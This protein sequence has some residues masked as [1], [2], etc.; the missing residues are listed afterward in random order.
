[1]AMLQVDRIAIARGVSLSRLQ[2]DSRL[3]MSIVSRYWH[4]K[5]RS[6]S[7]DILEAIA[8]ALDCQVTDLI[9]NERD[10]QG[11]D[12]KADIERLRATSPDLA[13]AL[14]DALMEGKIAAPVQLPLTDTDGE[15]QAVHMPERQATEV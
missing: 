2:L 5:V 7:L 11:D 9:S 3:N 6:V 14:Y 8:E 13:Q 4:N 10:V 1:M 12:I 15:I